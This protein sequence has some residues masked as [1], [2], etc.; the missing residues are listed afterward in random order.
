MT[1][2][3]KLAIII[4]VSLVGVYIALSALGIIPGYSCTPDSYSGCNY[5]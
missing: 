3:E 2:K 1:K 4:D 5:P